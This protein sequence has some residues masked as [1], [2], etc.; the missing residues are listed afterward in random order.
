MTSFGLTEE[1]FPPGFF[2]KNLCSDNKS[3]KRTFL[4]VPPAD[5]PLMGSGT[6]TPQPDAV[7]RAAKKAPPGCEIKATGLWY[8]PVLRRSQVLSDFAVR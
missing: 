8:R 7:R 4:P 3:K 2:E 5:W 6:A 1:V